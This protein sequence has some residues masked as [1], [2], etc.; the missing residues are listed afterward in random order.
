M[1]LCCFWFWANKCWVACAVGNPDKERELRDRGCELMHLPNERN[2]VD[3]GALMRQ[4]GES[5][6]NELHV[7]A[8]YKLNGSLVRAGL[9]SRTQARITWVEPVLDFFQRYG[10]RT[11]WLLLALVGLYRISDIVL[12]VISNVF[13]QDMGFTKP[14]IAYAVKT[15]GVVIS[16]FGGFMG[17]ILATRFGVMRSLMWGAILAAGTNLAFVVL[18]QAGHNLTLLYVIVSADNL[19]AGF[20]SAAFVAFLSSLTNVSFTAVQYAIFSSL[21]TLLP[22]TLGG[23]SGGMVD[24]MGYPGFFVFTALI[25]LPVMAL[26]WL[27]GRR[28]EIAEPVMRG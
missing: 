15:Y 1:Q 24:G 26:V 27:A 20:A 19:A 5:G 2:K 13:Y 22:K 8:G 9:A 16:I 17:G 11:A 7:E 25:G 10:V 23:Y 12:G 14:E 3:L 4:L 6:I 21:M 28:L 18:A